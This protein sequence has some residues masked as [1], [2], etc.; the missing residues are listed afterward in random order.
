M[1]E[2]ELDIP[3]VRRSQI[4]W[5]ALLDR[6]GC[7]Q[8]PAAHDALTAKLIERAG[9]PAYQVGGF[10]LVG[11]RY[12]R[13]DVDLEHFGEKNRAVQDI[14]DGCALPV[15]VDCDDGYGDAKNVTRTV[16]GYEALGAAALFIEDQTAPKR[17]GHMAGKTVVPVEQM[18]GKIRAAVAARQE[19]DTFILARTDAI[20]PEG[21]DSALRRADAYLQAGADGVYVEGPRNRAELEQIGRALGGV[22]LATSVLERGG[23]T[24]WLSP[25][26]FKALG[27]S[28]ILYP[29]TLL[30]RLVRAIER[31]LDDLRAGGPLDETD[32]IDF[33]R[34]EDLADL[35]KWGAIEDRYTP[36]QG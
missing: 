22:P 5:K 4:S 7:L 15:L 33:A 9:F 3:A 29:T 17:C 23:V 35:E 11:T 26:E 16:R 2:P 20:E 19:R 34:F 14:I 10:A 8:L 12:G 21:V 18:V 13:P 31:G 24:P 1:D 32:S 36:K 30:F 28:M 25:G 27:Y 6:E